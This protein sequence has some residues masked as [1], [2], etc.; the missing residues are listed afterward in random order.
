VTAPLSRCPATQKL[1]L[2]FA[3]SNFLTPESRPCILGRARRHW[4]FTFVIVLCQTCFL[5]E[6][7]AQDTPSLK[8]D[9]H[10]FAERLEALKPWG[11]ADYTKDGWD[12][13][14][15]LGMLVQR[16]DPN[17]VSSAIHEFLTTVH[18]PSET[19]FVGQ[20]T[21][22]LLLLRIVFD[23]PERFPA[24]RR[25]FGEGFL[26]VPFEWKAPRRVSVSWPIA[27][28]LGRPQL[29]AI[30]LGKCGSPYDAAAEYRYF[31]SRYRLRDLSVYWNEPPTS[32]LE[33]E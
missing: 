25:F 24:E 1:C 28:N 20:N 12:R 11:G 18:N 16:M 15:S 6:G 5:T 33:R 7:R 3:G 23:L 26:T 29:L 27:W 21:K 17:E 10:E 4:L 19:G 13:L 2:T 30:C 14:V 9:H 31:H 32:P 22:L 8:L